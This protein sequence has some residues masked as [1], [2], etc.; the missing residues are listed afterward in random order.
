MWWAGNCSAAARLV[1]MLSSNMKSYW[2]GKLLS[3]IL[4]WCLA[5][6]TVRQ[7]DT[8]Q[9]RSQPRNNISA[10]YWECLFESETKVKLDLKNIPN[11]T[12]ICV[13][14][15]L[16]TTGPAPHW[17]LQ[18][19][20]KLQCSHLSRIPFMKNKNYWERLRESQMLSQ[21]RRLERY[22]IIYIWKIIEG[23]VPNCGVKTQDLPRHGRLCVVPPIKQCTNRVKT[24]RENSF[25]IQGPILFN[26]F[27]AHIR[28]K[29]KFSSDEFK[30]VLDKFL[31]LLLDEPNINGTQ[32]TPKASCQITGKPSNK[33]VNQIKLLG[34]WKA[35]FL[36]STFWKFSYSGF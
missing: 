14:T 7:Y 2:K 31:E 30:D 9:T 8:L 33:L 13:K 5:N 34:A 17:L 32:Y 29:Q 20:G 24:L 3:R 19:P 21:E 10:S 6:K 35:P 1:W 23:K 18:S 36:I 4:N 25:Q 16:E 26:S 22:K 27:L 11:Q 15:T 12:A 28:N